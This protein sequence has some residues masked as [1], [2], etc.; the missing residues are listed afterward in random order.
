[1]SSLVNEQEVSNDSTNDVNSDVNVPMN[2]I[3]ENILEWV[4]E[5]KMFIMWGL[6]VLAGIVY[7]TYFRNSDPVEESKEIDNLILGEDEETDDLMKNLDIN[8]SKNTK[9]EHLNELSEDND[10]EDS[11][12]EDSD[13]ENKIDTLSNDLDKLEEYT[14]DSM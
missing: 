1:M 5:H 3:V 7:I 8:L 14:Q 12:D 10:K 13:D 4:N 9:E 11:D 6:I 2:T